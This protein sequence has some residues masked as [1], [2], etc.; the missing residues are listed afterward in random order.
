MKEVKIT[1]Y[2]LDGTETTVPISGKTTHELNTNINNF[3]NNM[4]WDKKYTDVTAERDEKNGKWYS[5]G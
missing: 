3:L 2:N 5:I 4:K 1:H